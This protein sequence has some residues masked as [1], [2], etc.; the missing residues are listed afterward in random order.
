MELDTIT[1][2]LL[3]AVVRKTSEPNLASVKPDT[4]T[5]GV[6]FAEVHKTSEPNPASVEPDM[7]GVI[8]SCKES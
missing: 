5:Q 6:L 7:S 4:I 1:Q 2:G 3:F 8:R